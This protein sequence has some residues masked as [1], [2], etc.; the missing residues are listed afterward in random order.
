MGH[1]ICRMEEESVLLTKVTMTDHT[2]TTIDLHLIDIIV[3]QVAIKISLMEVVI[4][5]T[6][7]NL[8]VTTTIKG[9]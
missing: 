3:T 9:M 4:I 6:T 5:R 7:I 1:Q 2:T 8:T